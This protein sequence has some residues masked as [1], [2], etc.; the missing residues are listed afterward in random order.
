MS[1]PHTAHTVAIRGARW[2]LAMVVCVPN[3]QAAIS[4]STTAYCFDSLGGIV[5]TFEGAGAVSCDFQSSNVAHTAS[6]KASVT[7]KAGQRSVGVTSSA[8]ASL[9]RV[10]DH[11]PA[12]TVV[13]GR[14]RITLTDSL[15]VLAKDAYGNAIGAGFMD[16]DVLASGELSLSGSGAGISGLSFAQL[17]YD[18][19]LQSGSGSS[20]VVKIDYVDT[21]PLQALLSKRVQWT[22]GERLL[23]TLELEAGTDAAMTADGS[24]EAKVNFG[25][26]LD[27]LGARKVT[28]LNGLPVASFSMVSAE[29]GVDWGAYTPAVPE[30]GGWALMLLGLSGLGA[31]RH[32]RPSQPAS[33]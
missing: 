12:Q 2:L 7:L 28:D 13:Q 8:S 23:L 14:G 16:V 17:R 1:S 5:K 21:V 32:A 11:L 25:N 9:E 15:D 22:A 31:L 18:F 19:H 26:S 30:P 6:G 10:Y 4:T 3:A 27:W 20:E 33:P 24:A 29:T